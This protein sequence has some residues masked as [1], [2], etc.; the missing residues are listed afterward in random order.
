MS[1]QCWLLQNVEHCLQTSSSI[2]TETLQMHLC[3]GFRSSAFRYHERNFS[4]GFVFTK[5]VALDVG[6]TLR[7]MHISGISELNRTNRQLLGSHRFLY[8]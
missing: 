6:N 2:Y 1:P 7:L 3:W 8:I 5:Y 4:Q